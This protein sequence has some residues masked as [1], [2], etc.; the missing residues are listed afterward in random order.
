M[1]AFQTPLRLGWP[2]SATHCMHLADGVVGT[3]TWMEIYSMDSALD[4]NRVTS[5]RR[6]G[7]E[8]A[9]EHIAPS[10]TNPRSTNTRFP[11]A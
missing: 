9:A 2:D 4:A 7:I 6:T 10:R 8:A 11:C 5:D 1:H 3:Q